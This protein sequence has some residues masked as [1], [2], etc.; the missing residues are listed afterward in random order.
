LLR[1]TQRQEESWRFNRFTNSSYSV[2]REEIAVDVIGDWGEIEKLPC[3]GFDDGS[4]LTDGPEP[5]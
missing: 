4:L 5:Q 2:V 3:V 1:V